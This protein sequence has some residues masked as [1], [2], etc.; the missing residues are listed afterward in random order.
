MVKDILKN[1]VLI[2]FCVIISVICGILAIPGVVDEINKEISGEN[3]RECIEILDKKT[4]RI[5]DNGLTLEELANE[6][7]VNSNLS[8][9]EIDGYY[10]LY[11]RKGECKV[12]IYFDSENN[13]VSIQKD[14]PEGYN[15]GGVILSVMAFIIFPGI[16]LIIIILACLANIDEI[17]CENKEIVKYRK[18]R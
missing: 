9:S 12:N 15:V 16:L 4:E 8:K 1:L 7:D 3:R 6:E 5:E 17:I 13:I 14:Y 11:L 18:E 2:I 10:V